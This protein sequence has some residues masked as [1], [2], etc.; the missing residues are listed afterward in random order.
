ML[1]FEEIDTSGC[2]A[3]NKQ[4]ILEQLKKLKERL[5]NNKIENNGTVELRNVVMQF[6]P[7]APFV[8]LGIRKTNVEYVKKEYEWYRSMDLSIKGHVDDVAIWNSC[9]SKDDL[10]VVN[11]NY[12][13]LVYSKENGSQFDNAYNTLVNNAGT[14]N[15]IIVYQRPSI[16]TDY[17][18]NGMR[19]MICTWYSHFFIRDNTLQMTHAMRSNDAIF[20][21]LNDLPWSCAVYQDMYNHLKEVYPELKTGVITW[22]DDS[23][24]VYSRHF[25]LLRKIE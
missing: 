1:K 24:H 21:L 6:D 12:G 16:Y 11:S 10:Q 15:A 13:Y 22:I 4:T 19:D 17:L 8:D 7:Y 3:L 18:K 5:E 23:L 14:R 25:E 9:A 2:A 20:G